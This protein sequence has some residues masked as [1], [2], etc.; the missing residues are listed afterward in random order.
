MVTKQTNQPGNLTMGDSQIL[1]GAY[2]DVEADC[3][4]VGITEGGVSYN[5]STELY[6]ASG[7]Q[8]LSVIAVKKIGERLEVSYTIKEDTLENLALAWDLPDSAVDT[9]NNE[10]TFGGDDTVNYRTLIINGPAPDGGTAKWELWKVVA[11]D[12]GETTYNKEGEALKE[13]TM[14][15]LEDTTKSKGQ[16]FGKRSDVYDDTTPPAVSSVSPTDAATGVAVNTTV[17]WTFSEPIQM[18]DITAGNFNVVDASGSEVA[19][20]LAYDKGTNKVIFTPDSDLASLTTYLAFVSG[21]V[22]DLAG[23]KMGSN[24]RTSFETA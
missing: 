2:G 16:R 13:I 7:D 6:E 19:G 14:L 8:F 22:K 17:E 15:V 1:V 5:Y 11:M 20:S 23:N 3:R 9:N 12:I 24:Y 18:R 21:E 10:I 4:D